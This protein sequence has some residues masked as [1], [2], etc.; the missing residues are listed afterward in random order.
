MKAIALAMILGTC[1][2]WLPVAARGQTPVTPSPTLSSGGT[3]AAVVRMTWD[4]TSIAGADGIR[5]RILKG[6]PGS[7]VADAELVAEGEISERTGS[8]DKNLRNWGPVLDAT[9]YFFRVRALQSGTNVAENS[10]PAIFEQSISPDGMFTVTAGSTPNQ[11]KLDWNL[12]GALGACGDRIAWEIKKASFADPQAPDPA[13]LVKGTATG[14]SGSRTIDVSAHGT[15]TYHVRLVARH[16]GDTEDDD[17]GR[18]GTA[19]QVTI[20]STQPVAV[21]LTINIEDIAFSTCAGGS[22]AVPGATVRVTGGGFDQTRTADLAGRAVFSVPSGVSYTIIASSSTCLGSAVAT[23]MPTA[24]TTQTV[25]LPNCFH[26]SADLVLTSPEPWPG[27]TAGSPYYMKL[28]V[29]H[30]GLGGPSRPADLR[31]VRVT[32]G[33]STAAT[34]STQVYASP[35]GAFCPS[36]VRTITGVD[37]SPPSGTWMYHAI[38]VATGTTTLLTDRDDINNMITRLNVSFGAAPSADPTFLNITSFRLQAGAASVMTGTPVSLN[39][40]TNGQVPRDYKAGECGSPF[41]TATFRAYVASPVPTLA[42]FTTAGSKIVC[43]QMRGSSVTSAVA[44]DTIVAV[45]PAELNPSVAQSFNP[46]TAGQQQT[47]TVTVANSGGLPAGGVIVRSTISENLEFGS[48]T[49]LPFNLACS[50]SGT[51]VTCTVPVVSAGQSATIRIV[52]R[53]PLTAKSGHDVSFSTSVDPE[54]A[55]P[56]SNNENNT[57]TAIASTLAAARLEEERLAEHGSFSGLGVMDLDCKKYYGPEFVMVGVDGKEGEGVDEIRV[58]CAPVQSSGPLLGPVQWTPL[59]GDIRVGALGIVTGGTPFEPR[60]CPQGEVV[61][62]ISGT[63]LRGDVRSM[64]FYCQQ[65]FPSGLTAGFRRPLVPIGTNSPIPWGPD[66][67][68]QGRPA[69]ALRTNTTLFLAAIVI[70]DVQMICEQPLVE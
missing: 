28:T 15:G 19:R 21:A 68:T 47:Y 49:V 44:R 41:E 23:V 56:E 1:L 24:A 63:S 62:G 2:S 53:L 3:C 12:T 5:W 51:T 37:P 16:G 55:I 32:P 6:A 57:A 36:Q 61:T 66:V 30:A 35:L 25:R 4:V 13:A 46:I 22:V 17:V 26:S 10:Q 39:A 64:L 58:A 9:R 34:V 70:G 7:N 67:C 31:I 29:R 11:I 20:A 50:R 43:L 48:A 54:N 27:G 33:A 18:W 69:R 65:L 40:T 59:N 60:L 38:L 45:L 52:T 8:R 42:G 14:I